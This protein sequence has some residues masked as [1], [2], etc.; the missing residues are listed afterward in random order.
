MAGD[1]EQPN[2]CTSGWSIAFSGTKRWVPFGP[3]MNATYWY[4]A[5]TRATTD[6]IGFKLQG[7]FGHARYQGYNVYDDQTGNFVWGSDSTNTSS[8]RDVDTVPDPGSK[9]P[10][11]LAVPRDTPE[12]D[13]TLWVVPEGTDTSGY[14]N[15]ITFPQKVEC[16]SIYLRVYLPDRNL[17]DDPNFLSG[18]VPLP[19]IQAYD[20]Q[21][22]PPTPVACPPT[23]FIIPSGN[24][25]T[26]MGANTKGQVLFYRFVGGG[27]YPNQDTAYL[28]SFF[29]P[30][31]DTV[32]I[33]RL[34]PPTYTNTANPAGSLLAQ[35]MA[36]YWSFNVYSQEIIN[37]TACL[38]DYQAKVARDG[39]VYLVLG[40]RKPEILEKAKGLNF[41]PWGPHKKIVL[42]YRNMVPEPYFP[43][44]AAA[45]PAFKTVE[46]EPPEA[47]SA[48]HFIGDYA[49]IGV[50]CT[51]A[52]FLKDFCGF[53]VSYP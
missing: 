14:S 26:P 22:D 35:P 38:A 9:N 40:R 4:F 49:P 15:V 8:L 33:I 24:M 6:T 50:Y 52:N 51:E 7:Q 48:D 3:D 41:L 44:S 10:Y 17:K 47:Q 45:V 13:Y 53:P 29:D 23:R 16:P 21:T 20:M 39:F 12:R 2:D 28:A 37:V 27:L 32:A 46:G 1:N 30:I 11:L 34:K 5:F 31:D 43:Y 25:P 36:R 19:N 42:G 18:G